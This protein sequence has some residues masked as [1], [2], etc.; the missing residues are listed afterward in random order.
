MQSL[1]N[2]TGGS[3]FDPSTP[4]SKKGS[5]K[6]RPSRRRLSFLGAEDASSS[7]VMEQSSS[8]AFLPSL[9]V[10]SKPIRGPKT[11]PSKLHWNGQ[12][13]YKLPTNLS[14]RDVL[15][16][17][18]K[19]TELAMKFK[20]FKDKGLEESVKGK[21]ARKEFV[22]MRGVL[23]TKNG[24]IEHE[25]KALERDGKPLGLISDVV[26]A[27]QESEG[28]WCGKVRWGKRKN[29]DWLEA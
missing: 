5:K 2:R 14:S 6:Q 11:S 22:D 19:V 26:E 25:R 4:A 9:L 28:V 27:L 16:L 1:Q 15:K 29:G 18:E 21:E 7:N 13:P 23:R 12:N 20:E 17:E 10:P 8:T 3:N 24:Q